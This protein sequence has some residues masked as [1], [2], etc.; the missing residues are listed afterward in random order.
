MSVL[1]GTVNVPVATSTAQSVNTTIPAAA[2]SALSS[3]ARELLAAPFRRFSALS[4]H[5]NRLVGLPSMATYLG[6]S[7]ITGPA[8]GAVVEATQTAAEAAREGVVE[9][10]AQADSSNHLT[11]IF[12]AVIKFSGFFSYLTSRWSLACFTV[13]KFYLPDSSH[14]H[15]ALIDQRPS[16]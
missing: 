12:Q 3:S 10:A 14:D 4:S 15:R 13:V 1:Q 11:D 9:A 16:F 6:G 8:G 2:T 7:G 5:V